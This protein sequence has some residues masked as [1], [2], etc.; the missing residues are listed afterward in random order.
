MH[1]QQF[2]NKKKFI[3]PNFDGEEVAPDMK[4]IEELYNLE[5][6]KTAKYA[7][8]LNNKVLHPQPIEKTKVDLA[9]RMFHESTINALEYHC[10]H[11]K[12]YFRKT[13][14]FFKP[15]RTWWDICNIHSL[16]IAKRK[17]DPLCQ[18]I[19]LDKNG[20]IKYLKSS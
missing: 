4:H 20:G 6:G 14:N 16:D 1:L 17:R 5:L 9:D 11:G 13:Y 10:E 2:F 3:C 18:P 7:H 19:S 8:K 12:P 15:I